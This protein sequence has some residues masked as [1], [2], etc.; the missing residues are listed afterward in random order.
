MIVVK[1]IRDYALKKDPLLESTIYIKKIV[2]MG[3]SASGEQDAVKKQ[4]LTIKEKLT[5]FVDSLPS[6]GIKWF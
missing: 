2:K 5:K 1:P 3:N 6:K 4:A